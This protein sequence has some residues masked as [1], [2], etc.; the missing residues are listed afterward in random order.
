ME[1]THQ[2]SEYSKSGYSRVGEIY[3][4]Y[5]VNLKLCKIPLHV[6]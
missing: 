5:L 1:I 2:L 4:G 3:S 6:W